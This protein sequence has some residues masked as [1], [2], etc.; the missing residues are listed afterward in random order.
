MKASL[1]VVSERGV[2]AMVKRGGGG[3]GWGRS[4]MEGGEVV[5]AREVEGMVLEFV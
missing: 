2:G 5:I 3:R 4:L 1:F